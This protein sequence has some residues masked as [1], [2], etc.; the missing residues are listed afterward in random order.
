MTHS[1]KKV[2]DRPVLKGPGC[3]GEPGAP[4]G[5]QTEPQ[6]GLR[7]DPNFLAGERQN[8]DSSA[9]FLLKIVE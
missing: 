6:Q 1:K 4:A 3:G 7:K 8:Q 9:R 5:M 2:Y